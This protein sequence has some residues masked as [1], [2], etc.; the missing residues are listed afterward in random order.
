MNFLVPRQLR[1]ES[2]S[3]INIVPLL[4]LVTSYTN[5][6]SFLA[7][8]LLCYIT[9]K[10][11]MED[12]VEDER[13]NTESLAE[14]E[15]TDDGLS[16]K[17]QEKFQGAEIPSIPD[18]SLLDQELD[19]TDSKESGMNSVVESTDAQEA[20]DKLEGTAELETT[21][22]DTI[23]KT[24]D[25]TTVQTCESEYREDYEDEA[26]NILR[27]ASSDSTASSEIPPP[28]PPDNDDGGDDDE[29][30][31][32]GGVP[33]DEEYEMD[34]KNGET[35]KD[36]I[37]PINYVEPLQQSTSQDNFTSSGAAKVESN[38]TCTK[39]ETRLVKA[40][41]DA[42]ITSHRSPDLIALTKEYQAVRKRLRSLIKST[43]AYQKATKQV[44][45]ARSVVSI[46][47]RSPQYT[48][49]IV[50]HTSF[51]V[52]SVISRIRVAF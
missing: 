14:A 38:G 5:Q 43:K 15:S 42:E 30:N 21:A 19:A 10:A 25:P 48:Y 16:L 37:T 23:N 39:I 17:E 1:T 47:V 34:R 32:E 31:S 45:Q 7:L 9:Q 33:T 28:P 40:I 11:M 44:E 2:S 22:E 29:I 50:A 49:T 35:E 41:E 3:V 36:I 4:C 46:H 12:Q 20:T 24:N 27:A 18:A 8:H 26:T 6:S 13:K 52:R 51:S